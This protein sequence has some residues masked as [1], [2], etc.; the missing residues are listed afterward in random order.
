[1]T[2]GEKLQTLR[3][4]AGMSQDALAEKLDVSRQ[5]VSKWE[6]DEAMPE[7]EKV[8]RIAKLFDTSLDELLLDRERKTEPEPLNQHRQPQNRDDHKSSGARAERFIR[9]HGYKAGYAMMAAGLGI[10]LVCLCLRGFWVGTV[11]GMSEGVNSF[12]GSMGSGVIVSGEM[13][14]FLNPMFGESVQS[15]TN[16]AASWGNLFL[17]GLIP[18]LGLVAAGLVVVIKGKKLAKETER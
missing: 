4:G 5:A 7:T 8:V 10:I 6:R 1:M 18:G 12:T 14:G 15:L 3:R 13:D 11:S 17:L 16:T 2:F 9:R